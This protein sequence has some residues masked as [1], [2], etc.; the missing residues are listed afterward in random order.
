VP[1]DAAGAEIGAEEERAVGHFE[2]EKEHEEGE[3]GRDAVD[4]VEGDVE[5]ISGCE[6]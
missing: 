5:V 4:G 3:D 6:K 2:A 1:G